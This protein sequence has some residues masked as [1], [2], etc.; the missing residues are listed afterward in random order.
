MRGLSRYVREKSHESRAL[1]GSGEFPLVLGAYAG[2][3][4]VDHAAVRV[5]E[6][7]QDFGVLIVDVLDIML[8]EITLFLHGDKDLRFKIDV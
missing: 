5:Q 3:R 1:D 2:A 8:A 7:A 4:A 6:S